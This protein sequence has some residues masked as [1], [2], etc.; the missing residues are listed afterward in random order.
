MS[1]PHCNR[2]AAAFEVDQQRGDLQL[3]A[4]RMLPSGLGALMRAFEQLKRRLTE[5]GLFAPERKRSIPD[6]PRVIGLVTS[7]SG[8]AMA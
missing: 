8:A 4:R 5:E 2:R 6:Y 7:P 3:I 1:L